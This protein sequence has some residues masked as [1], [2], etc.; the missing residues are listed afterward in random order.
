LTHEIHLLPLPV[1]I[2]VL[3]TPHDKNF[4]SG[5]D[6]ILPCQAAVDADVTAL[7]WTRP[8][9]EHN[10]YVCLVRDGIPDPTRQH[11]SYRGRVALADPQLRNGDLSLVLENATRSDTGTYECR[12]IRQEGRQKRATI[13]RE[14]VRIIQLLVLESGS[15]KY[16]GSVRKGYRI[17]LCCL[18]G[19]IHYCKGTQKKKTFPCYSEII[20]TR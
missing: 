8:D 5:R 6:V 1:C 11:P 13:Q 10:G 19:S 17:Q 3:N 9:L 16:G 4:H 7:E 14:P 20:K 15:R 2:W 18:N 12:L